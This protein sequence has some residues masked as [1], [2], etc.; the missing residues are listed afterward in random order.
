MN[1]YFGQIGGKLREIR[2]N[3]G[4]TLEVAAEKIG[5]TTKAIQFYETG[6]RQIK[7]PTIAKL[8]KIYDYDIDQ[9]WAETKIYLDLED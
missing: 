2:L 4:M 5:L 8:C 6:Q 3:K 7:Y 1:T 9:F